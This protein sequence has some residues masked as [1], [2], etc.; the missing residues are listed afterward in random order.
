MEEVVTVVI[1]NDGI[2]GINKVYR[3]VTVSIKSRP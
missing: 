3:K 1:A 2:V